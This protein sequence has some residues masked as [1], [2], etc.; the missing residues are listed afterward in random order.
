MVREVYRPRR[1]SGRTVREMAIPTTDRRTPA[2]VAVA[3]LVA[4]PWAIGAARAL[5]WDGSVLDVVACIVGF[6][7]TLPAG[8]ALILH[9]RPR[10][11][12]A[13][14]SLYF[15]VDALPFVALGVAAIVW[16]GLTTVV[17][18]GGALM[19]AWVFT[20]V[21]GAAFG[22]AAVGLT[23]AATRWEPSYEIA[24]VWQWRAR[25]WWS[26][27]GVATGVALLGAPLFVWS[28]DVIGA[29]LLAM[30][31]AGVLLAWVADSVGVDRRVLLLEV[32]LSTPVMAAAVAVQ[33]LNRFGVALA[34]IASAVVFAAL[35]S[36][37][38][39]NGRAASNAVAFS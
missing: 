36:R 22:W 3:W 20:G 12:M 38:V 34:G 19:V 23:V 7:V 39:L 13:A 32:A 6:W 35:A 1:R 10:R 30:I 4:L 26:A 8:F 28:D 16:G 15:A 9:M 18:V 31:V 21:A 14:T 25:T 11:P 27:A 17:E 29:V 37:A 24:R 33:D 2:M 5:R